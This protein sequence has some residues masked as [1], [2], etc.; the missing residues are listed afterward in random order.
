[1]AK[2]GYK[3]KPQSHQRM[4]KERIRILFEEAQSMHKKDSKLSDRYVALARKMSM[5][6]KVD[7][8]PE[9]KRRFCP[10]CYCY[11]VPGENLRVRTRDSKLVYYCTNCRKF[12]RKIVNPPKKT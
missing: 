9:L 12:W 4:A 3:S 10:H 8:P 1:M 6:Y 5:K 11:L 2:R 7:I